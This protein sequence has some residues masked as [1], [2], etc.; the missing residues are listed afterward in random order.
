MKIL[1]KKLL[2]ESL[3][4]S[5]FFIV[6]LPSNKENFYLEPLV[7]AKHQSF[8]ALNLLELVKNIKQFVRI[9]NC[10]KKITDSGFFIYITDKHF[11]EW[12][13]KL[14]HYYKF[15]YKEKPL[16]VLKNELRFPVL[17]S[18]SH[19]LRM[20]LSSDNGVAEKKAIYTLLKKNFYFIQ[21]MTTLLDLVCY[22]FYKIY[23]DL[24]DF[25]KLIFLFSLISK[26]LK[27]R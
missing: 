23:N 2:Y 17:G 7:R 20:L 14:F 19:T 21:Q 26:S 25:K 13:L 15:I 8:N 3:V 22:G 11:F 27:K 10:L 12:A 1:L 18:K 4:V 5:D 9:L 6:N 16:I 24:G